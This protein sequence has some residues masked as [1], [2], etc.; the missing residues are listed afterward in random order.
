[1]NGS[2]RLVARIDSLKRHAAAVELEYKNDDVRGKAGV[3]V[4]VLRRL[5]ATPIRPACCC[6]GRRCERMI[7]AIGR[8]NATVNR[9]TTLTSERRKGL[10]GTPDGDSRKATPAVA[11]IEH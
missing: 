11:R 2:L 3:V 4:G 6:A 10:I 5:R 1:L 8:T 9:L 7:D